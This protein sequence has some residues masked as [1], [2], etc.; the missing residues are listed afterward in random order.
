[1]TISRSKIL[2]LAT[3][4]ALPLAALFGTP[5][6]AAPGTPIGKPQMLAPHH[7][8]HAAL[9]SSLPPAKLVGAAG[10]RLT[11]PYGGAPIDV[12]TYHY[13]N[14]RT[15]WNQTETDLTPTSV[16]SANFGLL[17]TLNVDGNVLAQP[18]LV[19]NFVMPDHSTHDVLIIATG[20]TSV[21]AFDAQTYSLLWQVNL[22]TAQSST[23]VG[24]QDVQ[25]EYGISGTP[26]IVR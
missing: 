12:A 8:P 23:D 10:K 3:S 15:G 11:R 22:G 16:A 26:V 7:P 20:H 13:D 4:I 6:P 1:M 2:V 18:L 17:T 19:S 24:C 5:A 21:Y 25:P 14:N 9:R